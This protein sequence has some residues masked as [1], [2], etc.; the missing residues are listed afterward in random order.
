MTT[1][2]SGKAEGQGSHLRAIVTGGLLAGALDLAWAVAQSLVQGRSPL[3]ML[4]AIASGLLGKAAFDAGA[5]AQ[6]LGVVA[7]FTIAT[8]AAAVYVAAGRLVP[9]LHRRWYVAG[10]LF[11]IGVYF[12]MQLAV[13]P[14]SRVPWSV[15]WTPAGVALGLAAHVLCVGL[16]IAWAAKRFAAPT[17]LR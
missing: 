16:P 3:R 2:H 13:L 12:C 17:R 4:Q 8:G 9:A 15:T 5:A 6:A 1:V 10:P 14:L 11:G 7:H